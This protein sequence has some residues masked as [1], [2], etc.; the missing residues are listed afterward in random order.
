LRANLPARIRSACVE[1]GAG[2]ALLLGLQRLL[3]C[4]A[5]AAILE[6]QWLVAQPVPAEPAAAPRR[7]ASILVRELQAGD[8]ALDAFT[9]LPGEVGDRFAQGAVCLG[10]FRGQELLGWLWFTRGDFRDYTQP[11][12]FLLPG[13]RSSW[14]FDVYVRPEARLTAAFA[15]LWQAAFERLRAAGIS[16][17]ISA[18]SAFNPASLTAHQRLGSRPIGSFTLLKL[19]RVILV[20]GRGVAPRWQLGYSRDFRARLEVDAAAD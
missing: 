4:V 2:N 20:V 10:A 1:Y 7:G 12:E 13:S 17:S 15:R 8:P 5:P 16:R 18:I 14:D 11:L 3:A 9:R 6:R 19:G